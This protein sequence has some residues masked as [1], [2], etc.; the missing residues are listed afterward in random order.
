MQSQTGV[1][2]S[3]GA[4]LQPEL[5]FDG[6]RL[7]ECYFELADVEVGDDELAVHKGGGLALAAELYHL[8]HED[9]VAAHFTRF[10]ANVVCAEEAEGFCA[11]WAAR[12]DVKDR[13][14]HCGGR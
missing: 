2:R 4:R 11:P 14:V 10:V 12:F 5:C 8:L 6:G 1:W 13:C 7:I 3:R 9:F